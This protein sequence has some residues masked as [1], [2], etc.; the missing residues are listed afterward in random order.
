M[1][2]TVVLILNLD[3]YFRLI[4]CITVYCF[5]IF[6]SGGFQEG[7]HRAKH[8]KA[9]SNS[10]GQWLNEGSAYVQFNEFEYLYSLQ[11]QKWKKKNCFLLT[12]WTI[13]SDPIHKTIFKSWKWFCFKSKFKVSVKQKFSVLF[14]YFL[15]YFYCKIQ[16]FWSILMK[17]SWFW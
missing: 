11:G 8:M 7:S 17:F 5:I 9:A 1:S 12:D 14:Y 15:M 13:E 4:K 2:Q 16:Q 10:S 3:N 6:L